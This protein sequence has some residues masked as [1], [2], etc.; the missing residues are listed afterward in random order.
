LRKILE[1]LKRRRFDLPS[2]GYSHAELQ[3]LLAERREFD[4]KRFEN[5]LK[6]SV[7]QAYALL[8][9]KVPPSKKEHL[10][11][12]IEQYAN[13]HGVKKKNFAERAGEVLSLLLGL[14]Q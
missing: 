3:A 12:A 2:L 7:T 14:Q 5:R 8:Y 11:K 1:K 13:E 6:S 9:V 4:W 10:K